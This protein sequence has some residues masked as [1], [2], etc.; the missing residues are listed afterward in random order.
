[1]H[2]TECSLKIRLTL[3]LCDFFFFLMKKQEQ[4][5]EKWK[6]EECFNLISQN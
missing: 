5:K 4:S 3:R 2:V 6:E 1:M